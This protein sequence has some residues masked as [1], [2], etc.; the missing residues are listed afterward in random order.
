MY[1]VTM[2]ALV[3]SQKHSGQSDM[4]E[5]AQVAEVVLNGQAPLPYPAEG[6]VQRA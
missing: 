6:I 4:L 5:L 2:F 1:T 3:L